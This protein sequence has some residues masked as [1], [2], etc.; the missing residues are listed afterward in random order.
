[1]R[2][3]PFCFDAVI[4]CADET[5][6]CEILWIVADDIVEISCNHPGG[7]QI[8]GR[9]QM[10]VQIEIPLILRVLQRTI[11]GKIKD[12][13][14]FKQFGKIMEQGTPEQVFDHPQ[15]DRLRDFLS[16]VI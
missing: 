8:T 5:D 16:K 13:G 14:E 9:I 10:T 12:V 7:Q 1:M 6:L 15:C 3:L 4:G 2:N 11:F